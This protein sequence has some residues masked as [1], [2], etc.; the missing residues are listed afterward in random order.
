MN[1]AAMP[2]LEIFVSVRSR[3]EAAV[4]ARYPCVI[5][6]KA[7]DAGSLGAPHL[8]AVRSIALYAEARARP[9]SVALGDTAP[10]RT[11]DGCGVRELLSSVNV[12][13]VKLGT[14]ELRAHLTVREMTMLFA[15][16]VHQIKD[17]SPTTRVFIGCYADYRRCNAPNPLLGVQ[18]ALESGAD[19]ILVDTYR[20]HPRE[21]LFT[22]VTWQE[23]AELRR[24]CA[25]YLLLFAVAGNL[26]LPHVFL[27]KNVRPNYVGFRSAVTRGGRSRGTI[28]P[29]KL[30]S[31]FHAFNAARELACG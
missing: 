7:P 18:L 2:M 19:G 1:G 13:F 15:R 6:V 24:T 28:D 5:D 16:T 3:R 14:A 9:V 29:L 12:Q 25:G 31:L 11:R 20:K 17:A 8:D 4:A 21:N 26:R 22:H 27:L 30:H 23:L 10:W